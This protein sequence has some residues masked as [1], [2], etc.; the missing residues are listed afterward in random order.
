MMMSS[1]YVPTS[2]RDFLAALGGLTGLATVSALANLPAQP[3][4]SPSAK[5][6]GGVNASAQARAITVYKDPNC[7]CCKLWVAHM[8]KAGF[9]ATVHDTADMANTAD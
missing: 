6:A 8:Q 2:R 1:S 3:P 9:V 7:G 4:K 5:A